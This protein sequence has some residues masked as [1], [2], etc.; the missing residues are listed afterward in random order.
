MK[1]VGAS[2]SEPTQTEHHPHQQVQKPHSMSPLLL[3]W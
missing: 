3:Y 2:N 1:A